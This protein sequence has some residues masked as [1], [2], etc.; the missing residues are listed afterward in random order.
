MRVMTVSRD[1][2]VK[3]KL[4]ELYPDGVVKN[5]SQHT[6]FYQKVNNEKKRKGL[7]K[8]GDYLKQLG[9]QNVTI[10]KSMTYEVHLKRV[11][12]GLNEA[13]PDKKII[14][15]NFNNS[16][17]NIYKKIY[18]DT[19]NFC[20]KFGK[21]LY[22]FLAEQQFIFLKV[23]ATQYDIEI[24]YLLQKE[25]HVNEEVFL[26]LFN[27]SQRTIKS[28]ISEKNASTTK[29]I[30]DDLKQDKL[31]VFKDMIK[32]RTTYK[33]IKNETFYIF[34]NRNVHNPKFAL[35][36]IFK[37][38]QEDISCQCLFN[39]PDIL[40]QLLKYL[41]FHLL[42]PLHL[43]YVHNLIQKN[44]EVQLENNKYYLRLNDR[45]YVNRL[46]REYPTYFKDLNSLK[47]FFRLEHIDERKDEEYET[48]YSLIKSY[49]L[50]ELDAVYIPLKDRTNYN[51]I[52]NTGQQKYDLPIKD[53]I[54]CF[55]FIH[56]GKLS[57]M[58]IEKLNY[59]YT[60]EKNE[61]KLI[62]LQNK[63]NN[64]NITIQE[65]AYRSRKL[66]E[67]LKEIYGYKCQ[68][69]DENSPIPPIVL[70]NGR[71]YVEVHHI[72]A[73]KDQ[74]SFNDESDIILDNYKNA[75]VVCPH[76]H[77]YLHYHLGGFVKIKRKN[78]NYYFENEH[79]KLLIRSNHH[80]EENHELLKQLQVTN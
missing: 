9:F 47:K 31:N 16:N 75:M 8:I 72:I 54:E 63:V 6:N 57:A 62:D 59:T 46:I 10:K 24:I 17:K 14:E 28:F 44:N 2:E 37:N 71:C 45:L 65:L 22:D 41:H 27:L 79:E 15:F 18:D 3:S 76:H 26:K 60:D 58:D 66:V 32:T 35:L 64:K 13:F 80:L 5:L 50:P 29:W 49:Y 33:K 69:C 30:V 1:E 40:T 42:K 25:Y 43:E 7:K 74:D 39:I 73:L 36:Y 67:L 68:I 11:L 12:N 34:S 4:L 70:E 77:K 53:F 21:D 48:M 61:E 23:D 38:D 19:N 56:K 55:G 20:N 78:N 52:L 51:R